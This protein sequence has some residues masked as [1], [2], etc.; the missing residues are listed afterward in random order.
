MLSLHHEKILPNLHFKTPNPK[1]IWDDVCIKISTKEV[2]WK[3]GES[4]R[5]AGVNS[6]GYG[7]TNA[8][9]LLQE[10]PAHADDSEG[11]FPSSNWPLLLPI[12]ARSEEALRELTGKYAFF[13]AINS[14]DR[15]L[16]NFCYTA[17]FRRTH[18]DHRAAVLADDV[19]TLCTRLQQFS[20]GEIVD[21]LSSDLSDDKRA[22]ELVFVYTGMSPQWWAMGRELTEPIK[23]SILD[24]LSEISPRKTKIPLYSPV[25]GGRIKGDEL[26]ASYWWKNVR[27][28]VRFAQSVKA[29]L[30]DRCSDFLEIGHHPVLGHSVKELAANE[31]AAVRLTPSLHRKFP[32]QARMLESLGQMYAQGQEVNWEA[33]TP[34][35]GSH[36]QLPSY[37]WQKE[38]YRIESDASLQDRL[39]KSN[40][41]LLKDPRD[42]S[43]NAWR[44]EIGSEFFPCFKDHIVNEEIVFPGAGYVEA[45]LEAYRRRY[46][47]KVCVLRDIELHNL[48]FFKANE[49]QYLDT[50]VESGYGLSLGYGR[51]L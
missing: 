15:S 13:L 36:V 42:R 32:E 16:T 37:P 20:S 8:H 23:E 46:Y 43:D 50:I 5:Y 6:F 3:R 4:T 7:G 24:A 29:L 48:L 25:E 10:D 45:G 38:R 44:T 47:R 27:Q 12:S 21:Q 31:D 41:P 26:S 11:D 17:A 51:S 22:E 30:A 1:I 2:A 35:G 33:V 18:H 9:A 14:D 28:P 39:G 40:Y 49:V 19:E 34:R